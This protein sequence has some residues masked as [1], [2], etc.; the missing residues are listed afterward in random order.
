MSDVSYLSSKPIPV[1]ERLIVALDVETN[2]AAQA[3]VEQLGDTVHFYKVN[4]S[5]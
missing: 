4:D 1:E 3:L 5:R 2:A